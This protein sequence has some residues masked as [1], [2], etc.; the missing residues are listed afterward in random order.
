MMGTFQGIEPVGEPNRK[1]K[2]ET[3]RYY[4]SD[5]G[6]TMAGPGSALHWEERYGLVSTRSNELRSSK[7]SLPCHLGDDGMTA[8]RGTDSTGTDGG[9]SSSESDPVSLR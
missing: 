3:L 1:N 6:V 2:D 5:G 9:Y 4:Q 8:G 7:W